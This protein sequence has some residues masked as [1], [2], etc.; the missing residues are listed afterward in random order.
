MGAHLMG[1]ADQAEY[2]R[3]LAAVQSVLSPETFAHAWEAG[4]SL[5]FEQA[6]A[7]GLSPV[8]PSQIH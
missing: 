1:P 7:L 2:D 8:A 5:A 3:H 4:R 6:V